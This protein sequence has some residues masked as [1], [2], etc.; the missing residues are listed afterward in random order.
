MVAENNLV[1]VNASIAMPII[2]ERGSRLYFGF[3]REFFGEGIQLK[4]GDLILAT[5]SSQ[6]KDAISLLSPN[7]TETEIQIRE[8]ISPVEGLITLTP[9]GERSDSLGLWEIRR[10]NP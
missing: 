3:Y 6:V 2:G 9:W 7:L 5:T 4:A 1:W 8:I 10:V